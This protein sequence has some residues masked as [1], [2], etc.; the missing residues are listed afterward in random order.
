MR[1]GLKETW[2]FQCLVSILPWVAACPLGSSLKSSS[3]FIIKS[4]FPSYAYSS[5]FFFFYNQKSTTE[6]SS[7]WRARAGRLQV[8][9]LNWAKELVTQHPHTF[10]PEQWA[11]E[12]RRGSEWQS[13]LGLLASMQGPDVYP[14]NFITLPFFCTCAARQ[15]LLNL[16]HISDRG[17]SNRCL[18]CMLDFS[19]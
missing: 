1:G 18:L 10:S 13:I 7:S 16:P 17:L 5:G 3:V 19:D 9:W 8:S 6:F 15:C 12:G 11:K 14:Y 2:T 4:P